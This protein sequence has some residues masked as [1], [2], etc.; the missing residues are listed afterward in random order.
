MI[1]NINQSEASLG[2]ISLALLHNY[3]C[4]SQFVWSL[5]FSDST[6][7]AETLHTDVRRERDDG[8]NRFLP[9][10]ASYHSDTCS[11]IFLNFRVFCMCV[12]LPL[13]HVLLSLSFPRRS[14][15]VPSSVYLQPWKYSR[16]RIH[17][18]RK[19]GRTTPPSLRNRTDVFITFVHVLTHLNQPGPRCW[20]VKPY[21]RIVSPLLAVSREPKGQVSAPRRW[22]APMQSA[23]YVLCYCSSTTVWRTWGG[24]KK[25]HSNQPITSL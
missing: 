24:Q 22:T 16:F 20:V 8:K 18:F 1:M 7:V 15:H 17:C 9:N 2:E 14:H 12:L 23:V 6:Y 3:S 10:V 25:K 21:L 4:C 11:A 13:L 19:A 5:S